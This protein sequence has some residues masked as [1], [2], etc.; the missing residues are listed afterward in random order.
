MFDISLSKVITSVVEA[1]LARAAEPSEMGLLV[2]LG[3]FLW[4]FNLTHVRIEGLRINEDR[5]YEFDR[6]QPVE[7]ES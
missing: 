7:E 2:E 1:P 5:R 3:N 4:R 6:L